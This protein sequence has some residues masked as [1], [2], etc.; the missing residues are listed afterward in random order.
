M[1]NDILRVGKGKKKKL[2]ARKSVSRYRWTLSRNNPAN[3]HYKTLVV[4]RG[5]AAASKT[6]IQGATLERIFRSSLNKNR[7]PVPQGESFNYRIA[8]RKDPFPPSYRSRYIFLAL[9]DF[10]LD[11]FFEKSNRRKK[12]KNEHSRENSTIGHEFRRTIRSTVHGEA[13]LI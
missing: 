5:A 1:E 9:T 8:D 2:V 10:N 7:Y 6:Y 3:L 13:E 12:R 11:C 4:C